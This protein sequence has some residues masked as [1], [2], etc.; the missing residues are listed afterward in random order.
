MNLFKKSVVGQHSYFPKASNLLDRR[1]S[2]PQ[3][4][5]RLG[6]EGTAKV[7]HF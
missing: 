2:S 6:D 7:K 1:G 3:Q 5:I 4:R